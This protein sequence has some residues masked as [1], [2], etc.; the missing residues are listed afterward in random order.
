MRASAGPLRIV[1]IEDDPEM[2]ELITLILNGAQFEVLGAAGGCAGL[3]LVA[4]VRPALVLLDLMMPDMD[5][6]E[7]YRRLRADDELKEIPVIVI[8]ARAKSID[9]TLGLRVAKVDDYLTKPFSPAELQASVLRVLR[10]A[11]ITAE[12]EGPRRPGT[13]RD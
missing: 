1:C 13:R 11:G 9:K 7:V 5:G 4:R 12:A 10:A 8:T 2:I 3:E 6:W